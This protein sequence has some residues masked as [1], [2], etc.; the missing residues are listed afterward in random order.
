M[1]PAGRPRIAKEKRRRVNLMLDPNTYEYLKKVGDGSASMGIYLITIKHMAQAIHDKVKS[2][3]MPKE[4]R[5]PKSKDL[6]G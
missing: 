5:R 2:L 3:P 4:K 1:A 6:Y